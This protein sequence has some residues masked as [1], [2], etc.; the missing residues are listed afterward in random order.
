MAKYII[1]NWKD[2]N[3]TDTTGPELRDVL[4]RSHISGPN[5]AHYELLREP[6]HTDEDIETA[7][8]FIRRNFD[9]VSIKV[10]VEKN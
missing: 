4:F 3:P 9:P 8:R 1:T 2:F 10:Y 7:K 6:H 5:G